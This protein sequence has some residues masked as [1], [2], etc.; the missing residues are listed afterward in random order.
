[1]DWDQLL[2]V[3]SIGLPQPIVRDEKH[4]SPEDTNVSPECS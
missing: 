1:M 3:A 2:E 4:L